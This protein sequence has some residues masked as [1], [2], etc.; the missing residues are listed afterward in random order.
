MKC[1]KLELRSVR[2][3]LGDPIPNQWW[4]LRINNNKVS[5]RWTNQNFSLDKSPC[6]IDWPRCNQ[7]PVTDSLT[8]TGPFSCNHLRIL[9]FTTKQL[10]NITS[11]CSISISYEGA[12][13]KWSILS[14]KLSN[15]E[16]QIDERKR[17]GELQL[18]TINTLTHTNH[19]I[20]SN[21]Y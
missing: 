2:K 17:G 15:N 19:V 14:T 8:Q 4:L 11:N 7:I 21:H 3:R 16:A 6:K 12:L 18:K 20:N 10:P 13:S 1:L 9:T 5:Y